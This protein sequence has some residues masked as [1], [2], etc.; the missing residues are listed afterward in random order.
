MRALVRYCVRESEREMLRAGPGLLRSLLIL[1]VAHIK[2][3][4]LMALGR[5]VLG[6]VLALVFIG[7]PSGAAQVV[8][9]AIGQVGTEIVTA[10]EVWLSLA[11]ENLRFQ[12]EKAQVSDQKLELLGP[13]VSASVWRLGP[14]S[15]G[16][17]QAASALML[18]KMMAQEA[19]SF[20]LVDVSEKKVSLDSVALV[21]HYGVLSEFRELEYKKSEV[22]RLLARKKQ[23]QEFLRFKTESA[24]VVISDDEAKAYY[25]KNRLKFGSLPFSQFKDSIKDVL[26]KQRLEERLKDWF[27]VLKRKYRVRFLGQ[28][29]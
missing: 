22:E 6:F 28:F 12:L 20:S 9:V 15:D 2:T 21:N 3:S 10:R 29:E 17:K 24:G 23:A 8:N 11:F 5:H 16:F 1:I 4:F 25:E 27:E 14:E 19:A 7:V 13:P 26:A 18:E